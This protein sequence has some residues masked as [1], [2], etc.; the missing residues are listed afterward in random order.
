[1]FYKNRIAG[2]AVLATL[3]LSGIAVAQDRDDYRDRD[4][5]GYQDRDDRDRDRDRDR[6]GDRDRDDHR[7]HGADVARDWGS[8]DGADV[9]RADWSHHKSFNPNPRGR[10]K[11]ADRGYDRRFGEVHEYRLEYSRAYHEAYEHAWQGDG[12]KR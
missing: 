7:F 12:W 11:N 8:R 9:A 1:M 10:Y 5:W 3:F 6:D 2:L 4:R